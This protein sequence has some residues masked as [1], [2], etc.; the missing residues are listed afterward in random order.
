[1]V[2]GTSFVSSA[3]KYPETR[4]IHY[5]DDLLIAA[6]TQQELQKARDCV[7]AEVQNAGLE[8]STSKI[9]EVAP[10]KYLGWRIS[11]QT[12]RHQ[13][14]QIKAEVN[15]LQDLQQLLGEINWMRP[16]LGITNDELTSLFNLLRGDCN[17]KSPRTLTPE[18]QEALERIA[19]ALQQRQA[20]RFVESLPFFL[21]VLGEKYNCMV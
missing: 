21:A 14:I 6:L 16:V 13:K 17:I 11:E 15:N 4:I 12:I 8:I 19:E 2:C 9:Q 10:W 7:I 20:H 1:M 18:A 3:E 5:M